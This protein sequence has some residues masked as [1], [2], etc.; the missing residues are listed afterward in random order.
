MAPYVRILVT[1][2]RDW[3][4]EMPIWIA[5]EQ[6]TPSNPKLMHTVKLVHGGQVSTDPV[7]GEKYGADYLA[8]IIWTGNIGCPEEAHPADWKRYGR[9]AG[10][11]RN[12]E[13][14]DAGADLCVAFP[15]PQSRGTID[16]M[17]RAKAAGIPI[18]VP[19][20]GSLKHK[21]AIP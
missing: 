2:S 10:M 6:F 11:R 1:G 17:R 18:W 5:L 14:V 9:A 3:R 15:L 20:G 19:A 8:S 7:T 13:M 12:Q 16:C 21:I 4:E